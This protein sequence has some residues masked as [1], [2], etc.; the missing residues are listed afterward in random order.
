[1]GK[2]AEQFFIAVV[3]DEAALRE[4]TDGLLR[5]A[6]FRAEGFAS[7]EDFL[8]SECRDRAGCLILDVRLPG[9]SGLELQQHLARTG[10]YIPIVFITAQE[11][12]GG[13][14]KAQA[15]RAGAVAFLHKPFGDEDLLHAV[16]SA[17]EERKSARA[18][19]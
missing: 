14:M 4:A 18:A 11:D 13:R 9:M 16:R 5:S 8:R 12:S 1:M 10:C 19:E 15:L 2:P 17:S 3:D 7:A 6:G